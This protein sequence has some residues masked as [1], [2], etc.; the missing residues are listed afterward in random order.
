MN[1]ALYYRFIAHEVPAIAVG[2]HEFQIKKLRHMSKKY[3]LL[4]FLLPLIAFSSCSSLRIEKRHY[5]D[6]FYVNLNN[7]HKEKAAPESTDETQP[8]EN[9]TAIGNTETVVQETKTVEEVPQI[10]TP[11][12]AVQQVPEEKVAVAPVENTLA[13]ETEKTN[14]PE[15]ASAPAAENEG[16][17]QGDVELILLVILAILLPPLAVFL[18]QGVTKWFWI[19][20]ILCI[21][22]GGVFFYPV[23]GG[24]WLI[25][26]IIA[27]FVVFGL[28]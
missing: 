1:F 2:V 25:A 4:L 10:S 12:P 8:V 18:E 26:V 9:S 22:G 15:V 3:Y 28:I 24:L 11:A 6:G 5:R 13:P 20:L 21:F 17:P 7:H 16:Q 27:L 23:I 19:T 14:A